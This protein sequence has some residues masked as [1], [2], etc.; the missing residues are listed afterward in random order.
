MVSSPSI[1]VYWDTGAWISMLLLLL[2]QYNQIRAKS[3]QP[4]Q[5]KRSWSSHLIAIK[6]CFINDAAHS[7]RCEHYIIQNQNEINAILHFIPP[8]PP[9][10]GFFFL[11]RIAFNPIY[12][13]VAK[14]WETTHTFFHIAFCHLECVPIFHVKKSVFVVCVHYLIVHHTYET[15]VKCVVCHSFKR[16]HFSWIDAEQQLKFDHFE[17][18]RN[19]AQLISLKV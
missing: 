8:P 16:T 12:V 15:V 19:V 11:L 2:Q 1:V 3:V 5:C 10:N 4:D 9:T 17:L 18:L 13:R 6:L 14:L 7:F